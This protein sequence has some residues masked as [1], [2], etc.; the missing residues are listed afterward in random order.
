VGDLF[1]REFVNDSEDELESWQVEK[2]NGGA[3]HFFGGGGE[4]AIAPITF[5]LLVV[6][7]FLLFYLP[8]KHAFIPLIVAATIL[9]LNQQLIVAGVHLT[10]S[11][12][13]IAFGWIR[14]IRIRTQGARLLEG[15]WNRID[16]AFVIYCFSAA[17]FFVVLWGGTPG[18]LIN[19]LGFLYNALGMYW[20]ARCFLKTEADIQTA[21]KT[22]V[23]LFAVIA[24]GMVAQHVKSSNIFSYLGGVPDL[25]DVRNGKIRSQGPFVHPLTAGAIGSVILP[26]AVGLWWNDAGK[27]RKLA[28]SIGIASSLAI[29]AT[30]SSSTGI[31]TLAAAIMALFLWPLRSYL[32]AMRWALLLTL[33]SLH[34]VMK[35]PVWALI[36]RIDLTGSSSGYHR[37]QLVDQFVRRFNEWWLVGTRTTMEWGWDMWDTINCYVSAGT[38][39]GIVTFTAFVALLTISFQQLGLKRRRDPGRARQYWVLGS[40]LFAQVLAFFGIE[41]FDQSQF[42]WFTMLALISSAVSMPIATAKQTLGTTTANAAIHSEEQWWGVVQDVNPGVAK[43]MDFHRPEH[44]LN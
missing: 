31:L 27:K 38:G 14:V 26:L 23:W 28:A 24:L 9:P 12:L 22:L 30:S 13:L 42:V 29:G 1:R 39:G 25:S 20:L 40:M 33:V 34:L 7:L 8:R 43:S 15:K 4:S 5:L 3:Q 44:L 6:T 16:I 21:S 2:M 41:Y 37:F 17:T 19:K 18:A 35:A 11:R 36:G 32:R 10:A